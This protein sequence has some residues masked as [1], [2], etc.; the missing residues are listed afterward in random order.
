MNK[1]FKWD[2]FITSLI[3]LWLSML[4]FTGFDIG[5]YIL[6]NPIGEMKWYTYLYDFFRSNILEFIIMI[7]VSFTVLNSICGI[8]IFLRR[9]GESGNKQSGTIIVAK[10][11]RNVSSE[12]LLAYILPLIAFDFSILKDVILFAIYFFLLAWLCVRNNNVYTNIFLELKG[13]KVYECSFKRYVMNMPVVYSDS[14]IISK[15]DL[16]LLINNKIDYWDFDNDIYI[17]IGE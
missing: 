1:K 7:A 4:T 9:Q 2:M 17:D 6:G 13:Y 16:T 8:C 5:T 3:P 10:K 15:Q 14:L 12:F 11:L